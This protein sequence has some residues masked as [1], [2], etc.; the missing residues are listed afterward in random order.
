LG[1]AKEKGFE[2]RDGKI[3][4][5]FGESKRSEFLEEYKQ[6]HRISK[7]LAEAL[8]TICTGGYLGSCFGVE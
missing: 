8:L 3:A 4:T 1:I 5:I 7:I 2:I 6:A